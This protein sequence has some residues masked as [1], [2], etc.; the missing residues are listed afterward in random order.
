MVE[1]LQTLD[2]ADLDSVPGFGDRMDMLSTRVKE[3]LLDQEVQNEMGDDQSFPTCD[4]VIP[5]PPDGPMGA[6]IITDPVSDGKVTTAMAQMGAMQ[7]LVRRLIAG[8][9]NEVGYTHKPESL[10][11][12][13]MRKRMATAPH[14]S[15]PD[16]YIVSTFSILFKQ[17][18]GWSE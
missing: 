8:L 4:G 7:G 14:D 18:G 17:A 11:V 10:K 6:H 5:G 15:G 3:C 12:I 2:D 16:I 1:L 13:K 9:S